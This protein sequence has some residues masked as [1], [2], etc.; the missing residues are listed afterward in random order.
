MIR[1]SYS[2]VLRGH[3]GRARWTQSRLSLDGALLPQMRAALNDVCICMALSMFRDLV[4]LALT[5]TPRYL[6]VFSRVS[7]SHFNHAEVC[8]H[9][10]CAP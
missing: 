3:L 9:C 5:V 10:P 2:Y 1:H 7:Q 4:G 6:L 8:C